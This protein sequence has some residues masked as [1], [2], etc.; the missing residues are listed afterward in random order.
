MNEIVEKT[1]EEW[2]GKI[3]DNELSDK[4]GKALAD[5]SK[6]IAQVVFGE[7]LKTKDDTLKHNRSLSDSFCERNKLRWGSAFDLL[8]MLIEINVETVNSFKFTYDESADGDEEI[9]FDV[10]VKLHA[11]AIHIALEGL[12]LMEGGYADGAH[13]RWRA[14]HEISVVTIFLLKHGI[15]AVNRYLDHGQI[16]AYKAM[17]QCNKFADRTNFKS[18]D[19]DE[20]NEAKKLYDDVLDKYGNDFKLSNAWASPFLNNNPKRPTF[21][22]LEKS[23]DLDM[24]RPDYTWASQNVH[25][26]VRGLYVRLGVPDSESL[27][28]LAT[29][30]NY[31]M[32]DPGHAIALSLT[33]TLSAFLNIKSNFDTMIWVQVA[34]E[35]SDLIGEEFLK[36]S[37]QQ[38][39]EMLDEK[40]QQA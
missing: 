40:I 23:V 20:M 26:T 1:I 28:L 3:P 12:C 36:I 35:T 9:V 10:A 15:D 37:T 4:I 19:E 16:D 11:K 25:P 18:F 21:A 13:A 29:R 2:Q 14:L 7:L 27:K 8:E 31:G 38:E 32:T 22:D 17:K 5:T 34:L 24:I 6:D 30:S 33:K 39:K